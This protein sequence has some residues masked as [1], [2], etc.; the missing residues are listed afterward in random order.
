MDLRA[1]QSMIAVVL[2]AA[3]VASGTALIVTIHESR[4]LFQE[5]EALKR[6]HDRLRG[7]WSAY[8]LE[9]SFLAGH[10][11]IDKLARERFGM[12]DPGDRTVF[13]GAGR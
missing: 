1:I 8:T 5:R 4:T 6:E 13:I 10:T 9:V 11:E 3:I 12:I 2:L 7:E